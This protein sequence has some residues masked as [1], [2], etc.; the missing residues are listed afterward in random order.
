MLNPVNDRGQDHLRSTI[1]KANRPPNPPVTQ[2]LG[3]MQNSL[4]L[5]KKTAMVARLREAMDAKV[6]CPALVSRAL[7][8]SRPLFSQARDQPI[9]ALRPLM[10]AIWSAEI[11]GMFSYYRIAVV[12]LADIGLDMNL[13]L[14]C[15]AWLDEVFPQVSDWVKGCAIKGK[16]G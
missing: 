13:S 4:S 15:L 7:P 9:P 3:K 14:T 10:E 6:R 12:L 2:S 1:L 16:V 5:K 8:S 11:R